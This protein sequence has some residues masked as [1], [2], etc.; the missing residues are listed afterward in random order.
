MLLVRS[1]FYGNMVQFRVAFFSKEKAECVAEHAELMTCYCK[2]G[3]QL[4]CSPIHDKSGQCSLD[5]GKYMKFIE[6][7]TIWGS[8]VGRTES[9]AC[10]MYV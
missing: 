1:D 5:S 7:K 2:E 6:Q 3:F 10:F 4:V 8:N 9:A